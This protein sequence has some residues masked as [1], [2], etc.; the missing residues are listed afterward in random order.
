MPARSKVRESGAVLDLE[1]ADAQRI[2]AFNGFSEEAIW[3]SL[4]VSLDRSC[5]QKGLVR[6]TAFERRKE[7]P[8]M[9][10][11][12]TY[13]VFAYYYGPCEKSVRYEGHKEKIPLEQVYAS[14][15]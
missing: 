15:Q 2:Q 6:V 3:D 5:V 4:Q 7:Q 8:E 1:V 10:L 14:S 12:L 11:P 13:G 9:G